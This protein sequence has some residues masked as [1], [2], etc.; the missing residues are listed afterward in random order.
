[1]RI[2][3]PSSTTRWN[4]RFLE[5]IRN[6]RNEGLFTP[7]GLRNTIEMPGNNGGSN[8]SGAAADPEHGTMF[9]V[10]K[11]FPCMLKLSPRNAAGSGS[12]RYAMN[13]FGFMITSSGLSASRRPGRRSRRTI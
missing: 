10:S 4:A 9:V 12:T 6:A 11:D 7:P 2:S 8:W 13:G 3:A 1:M 5:D